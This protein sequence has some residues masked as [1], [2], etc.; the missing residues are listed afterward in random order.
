M[1]ELR[2]TLFETLHLYAPGDQPL[3]LGS[4]TTRSLIAYLLL[5]RARPSDRRR[6]AFLFWPAATEAAARR[7]LRQ[8][9]HHIRGALAA[10]D[11]EGDLLLTE[12]TNIQL[13]PR[14]EVCLDVET[15]VQETR[16]EAS[17][18]EMRHALSLYSGNLL[19]DI[20][21]DWCSLERDRLR[22]LWLSTLDR[23]SQALESSGQL[24][25]ALVVVQKWLAAE[26]FDENAL[27]R[28]MQI[29]A[30]NGDR[31]RAVH[32]YQGFARLLET[33]IGT[34]PLPETQE[35][36]HSIQNG[37]TPGREASA[38]SMKAASRPVQRKPAVPFVGRQK[39]I[40]ALEAVHQRARAGS[41]Q[42]VFITGEAG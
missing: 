36:L 30:L 42:L 35:L 19:E 23:Y 7:N 38:P 28:L 12:G 15:F 34:E 26:P 5:N 17:T 10:V 39:E 29:L 14:A 21:D 25:Q 18:D 33:E 31:A 2:A 20:Y 32:A 41:G 27:R 16:P 9:L 22:Q 40:A 24:N 3:D 1:T 11:P 6:L 37:Q 4:P 8:Y 13:N